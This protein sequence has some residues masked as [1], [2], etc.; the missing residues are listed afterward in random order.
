MLGA[1]AIMRHAG[2]APYGA[3]KAMRGA[4]VVLCLTSLAFMAG[5]QTAAA[6]NR[7]ASSD[8]AAVFGR[9]EGEPAPKG[10]ALIALFDGVRVGAADPHLPYVLARLKRALSSQD[11]LGVL[12]LVDP[13][14]YET[15]IALHTRAD[16]T[17][18]AALG[19]FACEFFSVC[20]ISKTYGFNDIVSAKV[21]A[22]TPEGG[23]T[24]GPVEVTLE[25]RM[26][27][28]LN[29]VSVIFYDP[30]SAKLSAASG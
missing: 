27:D 24:G 6:Q 15:Q 14:Y 20:D 17:P 12:E 22:V 11:L 9:E 18:G 28:G 8:A 5:G 30:S 3:A 13:A 29:L 26:W 1:T 7:V 16:R 10:D 23:L 25:L 4:A 21:L 2:R 19:A